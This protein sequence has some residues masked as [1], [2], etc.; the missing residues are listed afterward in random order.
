MVRHGV[1]EV[2][3]NQ[4]NSD[5][6][7]VSVCVCV[8]VFAS[9]FHC[10]WVVCCGFD[11][12]AESRVRHG[13]WCVSLCGCKVALVGGVYV[14]WVLLAVQVWKWAGG[15]RCVDLE[16]QKEGKKSTPKGRE[17]E[18]T[19]T[20]CV[21]VLAWIA[22][23]RRDE[24]EQQCWHPGWN[25]TPNRPWHLSKLR[26]LSVWDTVPRTHMPKHHPEWLRKSGA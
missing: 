9:F 6:A 13:V 1:S 12:L 24:M 4:K 2:T 25:E 10:E 5:L 21:I 11:V 20:V 26:Q 23:V 8:C 15:E 3:P 7:V 22:T 19:S 16:T 17:A 18:V 14:G